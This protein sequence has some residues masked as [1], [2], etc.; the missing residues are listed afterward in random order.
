MWSFLSSLSVCNN[1]H[2][3]SSPDPGP[4]CSVQFQPHIGINKK[5]RLLTSTQPLNPSVLVFCTV[6]PGPNQSCSS[7]SVARLLTNI[8]NPSNSQ[9]KIC[10]KLVKREKWESFPHNK[11][12]LTVRVESTE[13]RQASEAGHS[14]IRRGNH[15]SYLTQSSKWK[16]LQAR[17]IEHL[18]VLFFASQLY[19]RNY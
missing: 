10:G 16:V 8:S 4:E 3:A 11:K 13:G 14:D 9:G 19:P 2:L 18:R 7:S 15:L 6:R 17:K 1:F 5:E 12:I